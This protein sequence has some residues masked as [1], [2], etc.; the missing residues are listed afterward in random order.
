MNRLLDGV[1][2]LELGNFITGPCAGQLLAELGAEVTKVER[3]DGGDPFRGFAGAQ[4]SPQ[5]CAYNHGKRS[6]TVDITLP[7][8][9]E[10]L[11]RL[12]ARCDV[13]IENY[14]PGVLE[15]AGLGW[16]VLKMHHPRLIYCAISGFGPDGPYADRP[17][18]DTVAQAMSGFFSQVLDPERP[19]IPGPAMADTITGV[20]AAF[21]IAAALAERARTG[22][23]HRLDVAM[24]EAMAAFAAEPFAGFFATGR[25]TGPYDRAAMSQSF[26]LKC[27]DGRVIGVHLSSP[28]K[29]WEALLAAIERP[30]LAKD[31]RFLRRPD[32]MANFAQLCDELAAIFI[33]RPRREWEERLQRHDVPHAPVHTLGEAVEDPQMVHLGT[34]RTSP[35]PQLGTVRGVNAP[36]WCDRSRTPLDLPVPALGEHT[37]EQLGLAGFGA[38]EIAALRAAKAV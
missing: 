28:Q 25:S 16:E 26:A 15:R 27:A 19:R 30:D 11:L 32:R 10:V 29:F 13:L 8:G 22:V 38:D 2:V 18:Y 3:P 35:H 21:G 14:R 1:R 20:Y 34:F 24:V 12:V 23:G 36:I 31:P 5:F 17:A 9:R 4:F 37:E 7:Q 33:Q 6:V